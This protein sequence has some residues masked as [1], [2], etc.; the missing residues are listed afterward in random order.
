MTSAASG[1]EMFAVYCSSCHGKNAKGGPAPDLTTLAKRNNGQSPAVTIKK[2]IRGEVRV[3]SR[4]PK[5]MPAWASY[6]DTSV[7][8]A[9]LKLMSGSII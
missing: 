9:G 8:E 3:D 2:T 1:E 5:D 6:S 4:D 7:A